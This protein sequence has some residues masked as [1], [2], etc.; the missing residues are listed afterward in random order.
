MKKIISF[1]FFG[2]FMLLASCGK[3]TC[4]TCEINSIIFVAKSVACED[5]SDL[6][7]TTTVLGIG[8][9]STIKNMTLETWK[10]DQ[11]NDGA[12]CK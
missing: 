3:D 12:T 2:S 1:L 8:V 7:V 5:G 4:V 10:K 11:V 9:D 6:K